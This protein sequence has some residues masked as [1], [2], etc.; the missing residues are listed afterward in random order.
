MKDIHERLE[1]LHERDEDYDT[2]LHNSYCC[3]AEARGERDRTTDALNRE[4]R[5]REAE[6]VSYSITIDRIRK[7][8]ELL[9]VQV[10]ELEAE[11]KLEKQKNDDIAKIWREDA[12]QPR[13]S[14]KLVA[15]EEARK[16]VK[17]NAGEVEGNEDI[18]A[19]ELGRYCG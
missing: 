6:R 12:R 18:R 5:R 8:R 11:L 19:S 17:R 7:E 14:L 1:I 3:I 9:R 16:G 13:V 10:V 15:E 2:R 4:T